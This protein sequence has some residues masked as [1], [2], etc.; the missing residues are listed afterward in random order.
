MHDYKSLRI[1]VMIF[2]ALVNTVSDSFWP[3]LLAQPAELKRTETNLCVI[4]RSQTKN[5]VHKF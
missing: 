5:L 4:V 3:I 1:A 2:N